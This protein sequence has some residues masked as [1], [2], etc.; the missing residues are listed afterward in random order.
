[1]G[2]EKGS[3]SGALRGICAVRLLSRWGG[4]RRR[5]GNEVIA[6]VLCVLE[7]VISANLSCTKSIVSLVI[8]LLCSKIELGYG[9]EY[10]NPDQFMI[11]Y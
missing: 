2:K 3:G 4:G 1:M 11:G 6:E 9:I 10:T 5:S 7:N 8:S